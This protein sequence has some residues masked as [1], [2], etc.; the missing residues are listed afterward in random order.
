[1]HYSVKAGLIAQ[2][3]QVSQQRPRP[4]SQLERRA[5]ASPQVPRTEAYLAL[6]QP[7]RENAQPERP[8]SPK[9]MPKKQKQNKTSDYVKSTGIYNVHKQIYS[10]PEELKFHEGRDN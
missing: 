9:H 8:L 1:M 7:L 3:D 10:I 6:G 4:A 5:D 2:N